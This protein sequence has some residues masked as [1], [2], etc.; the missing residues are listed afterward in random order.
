MTLGERIDALQ[1][2]KV[3][4]R[5]LEA[6]VSDLEGQIRAAEEALLEEM[7]KQGVVQSRGH[8]ASVSIGDS[9]K[10]H[11]QDWSAFYEYIYRHKYFHL[12]DRRPSVSGCRELFENKGAIPG[13]VPFVQ[14]KVRTTTT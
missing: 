9:I 11:V 4:K 10:P 5:V 14:R 12:L 13:V 2:L 6:G 1:R 3:E 7:D 8:L